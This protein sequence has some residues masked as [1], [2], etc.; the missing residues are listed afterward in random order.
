[1]EREKREN[2]GGVSA[3][4]LELGERISKDKLPWGTLFST[5]C[6][7]HQEEKRDCLNNGNGSRSDQKI[8]EL[9]FC[10]YFEIG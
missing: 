4:M 3:G 8:L 5:S 10:C 1:M 2:D 9:C 7:H 6:S